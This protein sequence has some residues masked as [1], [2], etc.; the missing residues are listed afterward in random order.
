MTGGFYP[1]RTMRIGLIRHG[2]TDWN[3]G[4]LLQGLS[5]VPLNRRGRG[6]AR[7]AGRMLADRG[8]QR[9]YSSPLG[10]AMGTAQIIADECGLTSPLEVPGFVERDFGRFEGLSYI[11][12]DG[13]PID[14]DDPTVETEETVL[15]RGFAAMHDVADAHPEGNVL[16]I[17]H[18]T[19]IRSI[20]NRLMAFEGPLIGNASLSIVHVAPDR[21]M[22]VT[23]A[24]GY[25]VERF[26]SLDDAPA[27]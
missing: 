10:R 14:L 6:Q 21:A 3:A 19:V 18:G 16:L 4:G 1:G 25:P 20:L 17:G 23:L 27:T 7:H 26:T 13:H 8:W 11:G 12:A 15:E 5:D 9:V 24:G 2:E 22:H